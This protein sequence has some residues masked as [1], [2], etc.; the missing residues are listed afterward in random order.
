MG[1]KS[2][3]LIDL[4]R[5]GTGQHDRTVHGPRRAVLYC[6]NGHNRRTVG[7]VRGRAVYGTFG[8]YDVLHSSEDV[9]AHCKACP[10]G[11]GSYVIDLARLRVT[12]RGPHGGRLKV[13]AADVARRVTP[14]SSD[15]KS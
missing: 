5:Q 13:N 8:P 2:P 3:R 14:G 7:E 12:L 1:I 15:S 11:Q 6:E 9:W 10:T 4:Y